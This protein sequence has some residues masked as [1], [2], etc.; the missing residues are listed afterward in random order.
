MKHGAQYTK[1]YVVFCRPFPAL[2]INLRGWLTSQQEVVG[3][4]GDDGDVWQRVSEPGT[5]N[6]FLLGIIRN[7]DKVEN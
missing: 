3:N 1:R 5:E 4:V 7:S 6:S 2:L